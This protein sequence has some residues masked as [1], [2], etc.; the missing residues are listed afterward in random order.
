MSLVGQVDAN[1]IFPAGQQGDFEQAESRRLF[2]RLIGGVRQFSFC[3]VGGRIDDIRLVLGKVG[4]NHAFFGVH[5][6]VHDGEVFFLG[7]LPL[8]LEGEFDVFSF[9]E[10][11]YAGGPLVEAVDDED[12]PVRFRVAFADIVGEDVLGGSDFVRGRADGEQPGRLIDDDDVIIFVDDFE[13]LRQM[14]AIRRFFL[15]HIQLIA[16]WRSVIKSKSDF[17]TCLWRDDTIGKKLKIKRQNCGRPDGPGNF[18]T[19]R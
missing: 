8:V 18:G 4:G 2:E 17:C 5:L 16:D 19:K 13:V 15:S 11:K 10:Q 3:A 12:L 14:F 7:V 9:G 1:L 6:A